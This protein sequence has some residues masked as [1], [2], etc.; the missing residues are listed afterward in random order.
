MIENQ[1]RWVEIEGSRDHYLM[2]GEEQGHA[3]GLYHGA[4]FSSAR[5]KQIGTMLALRE[6]G[7]LAYAFDLP[8][9]G[10]S[11]SS[12]A[13]SRPWLLTLLDK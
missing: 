3:V 13:C 4:R 1:S 7:Y 10:K 6:A 11:P 2:E 5:W 12:A 9:F 8:G